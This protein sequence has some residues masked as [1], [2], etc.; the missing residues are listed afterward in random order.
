[1]SFS[2]EWLTKLESCPHSVASYETPA[3]GGDMKSFRPGYGKYETFG[4][5]ED[6][7]KELNKKHSGVRN[8]R[9]MVKKME[10]RRGVNRAAK[11][12]YITIDELKKFAKMAGSDINKYLDKEK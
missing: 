10:K 9:E 3:P 12:R 8:R 5:M 1:M 2:K 11:G 6:E 4:T 7:M